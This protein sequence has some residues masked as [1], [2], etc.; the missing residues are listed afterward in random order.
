MDQRLFW[1]L[2]KLIWDCN[3]DEAGVC[4]EPRV[5]WP[6]LIRSTQGAL[7]YQDGFLR[8]LKR[9]TE[10]W[11]SITC[12]YTLAYRANGHDA[13]YN[14]EKDV[15]NCALFC[16][17]TPETWPPSLSSC[18][19]YKL[20]LPTCMW[21]ERSI[22]L[23][24]ATNAMQCCIYPNISASFC[25]FTKIL[26]FK[27]ISCRAFSTAQANQPRL[28]IACIYPVTNF[29]TLGTCIRQQKAVQQTGTGMQL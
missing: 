12:R 11:K 28:H 16:L 26:P 13:F 21:C 29:R 24:V 8:R 18:C 9:Q 14:R 25:V 3:F 10:H 2:I 17:L 27:R 20:Q 6:L 22:P 23:L 19:L 7:L 1:R 4:A 15:Q 5:R